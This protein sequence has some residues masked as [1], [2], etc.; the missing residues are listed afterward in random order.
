MEESNMKFIISDIDNVILLTAETVRV[1]ATGMYVIDNRISIPPTTT[2]KIIDYTGELP[3]DFAP[4]KYCYSEDR[5]FVINEK[6]IREN[7]A[8]A[9]NSKV[10]ELDT[11]CNKTIIAGA[12]V[13]LKSGET[14][15]F[16]LDEHD[17]ANLTAIENKL[18]R[19]ATLVMWHEDNQDEH[20]KFFDA[21]DGWKIIDTLTDFKTYHITYFRDARIYI[22]SLTDA[23]VVNSFSYGD[24]IPDEYKSDVLKS[25]EA[26]MLNT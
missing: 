23:D 8:A 24:E 12:D 13:T 16:T 9:I 17:Q 4:R 26:A 14:L 1:T 11:T 25:L 22:R 7:L 2:F 3:E 21:E 18:I 19:G 20:C 6:F 15:H 5:G 10:E